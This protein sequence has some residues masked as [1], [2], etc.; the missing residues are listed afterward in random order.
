[1][2]KSDYWASWHRF[3]ENITTL[4][5]ATAENYFKRYISKLGII[6]DGDELAKQSEKMKREFAY[7]VRLTVKPVGNNTPW[8]RFAD[9]REFELVIP[10]NFKVLPDFK[11][12][13]G[14]DFDRIG[15]LASYAQSASS[16]LNK[17]R[18]VLPQYFVAYL[19]DYL[20]NLRILM[21]NL[22]SEKDEAWRDGKIIYAWNKVCNDG[23]AIEALCG[24]SHSLASD[25]ASDT[26][27]G[28]AQ[29][30]DAWGT[31]GDGKVYYQ[32]IINYNK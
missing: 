29:I 1:M 4:D 20:L 17:V 12:Q 24:V 16:L 2:T 22:Y 19:S 3:R 11:V 30:N 25:G 27:L 26:R 23:L 7:L 9:G 10:E 15:Q 5:Q 28:D 31:D 13:Y 18:V 32:E 14:K 21:N 6:Y 8:V